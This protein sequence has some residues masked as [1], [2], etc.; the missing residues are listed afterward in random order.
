M[1]MGDQAFPRVLV[2]EDKIL[3]V[4][5]GS[6]FEIGNIPLLLEMILVEFH[7]FIMVSINY[8]HIVPEV[9]CLARLSSFWLDLKPLLCFHHR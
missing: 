8:V 7:A 2:D 4:I 6:N 1:N 5:I 9:Q 3:G